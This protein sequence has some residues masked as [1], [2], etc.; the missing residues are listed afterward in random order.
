MLPQLRLNFCLQIRL[1]GAFLR[2]RTRRVRRGAALGWV[3]GGAVQTVRMRILLPPSEAKLPGGEGPPIVFGRDRLGVARRR[4]ATALSRFARTPSAADALELPPRTAALELAADRVVRTSPTMPALRRYRGIVYDGLSADT[5]VATARGRADDSILILSGLWG[6]VRGCERVPNYRLAASATLP[7]LGVMAGYWRP[8]LE[9]VMPKLVG[10][11]L[12]IDLRSSDYAA[13]W[14]PG[15]S[16]RERVVFV[17]VLSRRPGL[18]PAVISYPSKLGKG[19]LARALV[20]RPAPAVRVEDVIDAW[21]SSGGWDAE[22]H[23][24]SGTQH[25]DLII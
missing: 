4:A 15:P 1:P 19:Q 3:I 7:G 9:R 25:L 10:D 6:V 24:R 16:L 8:V 18:D 2:P 17:R 23:T 20:S 13:M 12:V 21:R 22:L 14:R 11:G 5:L